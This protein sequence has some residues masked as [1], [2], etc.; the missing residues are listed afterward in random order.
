MDSDK[1]AYLIEC[2]RYAHLFAA[3]KV[4]SKTFMH[5]LPSDPPEPRFIPW[6][7]GYPAAWRWRLTMYS[8]KTWKIIDTLSNQHTLTHTQPDSITWLLATLYTISSHPAEPKTNHRH[9]RDFYNRVQEITR[10]SYL[11]IAGEP[12]KSNDIKIP[13]T[14]TVEKFC[15]KV[16]QSCHSCW[17]GYNPRWYAAAVTYLYNEDDIEFVPLVLS[18][19]NE[20]ALT[21]AAL[22]FADRILVSRSVS[23]SMSK[24]AL[25]ILLH[26]MVST[27]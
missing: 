4:I 23:S 5:E 1:H 11:F 9:I 20:C 14:S 22:T 8:S 25:E 21:C 3:G 2:V 16:K 24:E 19:C 12:V 10:T 18:N 27:T 17:D 6:I 7:N 15:S 13:V 26:T